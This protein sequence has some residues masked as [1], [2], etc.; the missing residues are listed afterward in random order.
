MAPSLAVLGTG[1]DVGKSLLVAG[2]CRLLLRTGIRVAP[3][4]A[5]NMSLNSF[6]TREGGEIGRAQALQAQACGLSPHVDMNPILLKPE[7][8]SR[9]QVI[10]QGK[11]WGSRSA[12]DYFTQT[13][14]LF[15][16]VK[17]S[18]QRLAGQY[19]AIIIEGAGSAAELN[20]RDRDI[21]NWPV[22][23]M[24]K[25]SVVLVSDIDRGGVFAQ[26]LGT[27][28]LLAPEERQRVIGIVI[29]K[30]RGDA[31]LFEEG[32]RI[33][34]RRA[35]IP[36]LGV[37]PYLRHLELDQEDS[38]DCNGRRTSPFSSQTVNVAVILLPHMS[39]FTDFNSLEAE[40]DVAL[41][42]ISTPQE[43]QGA[44]VVILPGSKTTLA[45]LD[46]LKK[47]GF[48]RALAQHVDNG[49]EVV[50]ICGGFQMLSREIS[51]PEGV[52]TGGSSKGFGLLEVTTELR[53]HKT[54]LQVKASPLHMGQDHG[55][56]VE[57]YEIHIGITKRQSA[58]PC[59]RI[60]SS[61][62]HAPVP[63]SSGYKREGEEEVSLDG[64]ISNNTLVWGTY[65]HGVFDQPGFRRFWVNRVRRRKGLDP[66]DQG[67]SETVSTR[68]SNALDRWADHVHAHLN[69]NLI[70]STLRNQGSSSSLKV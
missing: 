14:D 28:D 60:I 23:E 50:G 30:F 55:Y 5:Q 22:V 3:F 19:E 12:S 61:H 13:P 31:K 34:E 37:L 63:I 1:S 36:V 51:D 38:L 46:Y 67:V 59:F 27:L 25:A 11:V 47:K 32:V 62:G 24:A 44:D 6:V 10:V 41:R 16:Y 4:K 8:D 21:V 2:L 56:M 58:K 65:I 49:G 33:I 53:T 39:N 69:V 40:S 70:F 20:L 54:T 15:E 68:L 7:M 52:E 26:V 64:G 43:L 18:Y 48:Q 66:L 57:G 29:N 45:D 9:S 42:Y 17:A 35:R